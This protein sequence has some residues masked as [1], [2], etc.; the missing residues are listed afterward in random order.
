MFS[1]QLHN[2]FRNSHVEFAYLRT[3]SADDKTIDEVTGNSEIIGAATNRLP[4]EFKDEHPDIDRLTIR[5][6]RNLMYSGIMSIIMNI[7]D[8]RSGISLR[9]F[10][11]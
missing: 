9:Y 7:A 11:F 8:Q 4:K 10:L 6:F 5:G 2:R 1:Q 3:V